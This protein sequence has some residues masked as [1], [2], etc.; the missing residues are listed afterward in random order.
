[1]GLWKRREERLFDALP[2]DRRANIEVVVSAYD[3]VLAG[4]AYLTMPVTTG[5]RFYDVLDHYGVRT[6]DDLERRRPG[7]LRDEIILPNLEEANRFAAALVTGAPLVV[8]GVFEARRQR[9]GQDEYMILWLRVITGSVTEL[10]LSDGWE[11]LTGGAME[12]CRAMMIDFRFVEGR[13]P[14]RSVRPPRRRGR[15]GYGYPNRLRP[16]GTCRTAASTPPSLGSNSA[17]WLG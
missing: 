5:R 1:M 7:A 15:S 17:N 16:F 10:W 9:W 11:Y 6:I 8:P 13:R 3:S 2:D 4:K 14:D 12:F